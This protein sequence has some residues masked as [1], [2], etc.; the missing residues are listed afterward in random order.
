MDHHYRW[1]MRLYERY[2]SCEIVI[3]KSQNESDLSSNG[4]AIN[5]ASTNNLRRSL[6]EF[7]T[8]QSYDALYF[9]EH[10]NTDKLF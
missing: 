1:P 7:I 4:S 5:S 9:I 10:A 3:H 8:Y 6:H 2:A